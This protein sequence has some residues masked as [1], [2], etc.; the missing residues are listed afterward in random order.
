MDD[1]KK[2]L[3]DILTAIDEVDSFFGNKPKLYENFSSDLFLRRAIER[4]IEIIGEATNRILKINP[5]IGITNSRK[6]VDAR[7]YI[8]HG[9]DSLSIDVLWSI[10]VNHLPKLKTEVTELLS[11]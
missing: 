2:N 5:N 6:I 8:I 4:E 3:S 10:V 7:N 11:E 9:Y 1:L